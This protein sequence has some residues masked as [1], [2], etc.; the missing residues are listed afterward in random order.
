MSPENI[1]KIIG[2]TLLIGIRLILVA[3]IILVGMLL[4]PIIAQNS[5]FSTDQAIMAYSFTTIVLFIVF[6]IKEQ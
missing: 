2:L 5:A 3:G 1:P 4:S 6:T